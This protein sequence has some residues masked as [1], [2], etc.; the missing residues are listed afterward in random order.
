[1]KFLS[2][3]VLSLPCASAFAGFLPKSI[4]GFTAPAYYDVLNNADL[5][6]LAAPGDIVYDTLNQQYYGKGSTA[7]AT[8]SPPAGSNVVFSTGSNER[9]ERT[10]VPAT[11]TVN[12]VCTP[13]T[14][15]PGISV[16]RTSLGHYD[17]NF[18]PAFA[19]EPSCAIT[20]GGG[21]TFNVSWNS[22]ST[23]TFAFGSYD[24]VG[25]SYVDVSFSI[26]CQGAN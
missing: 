2:A 21:G 17:I 26:L 7:W 6:T 22:I 12:G 19:Q 14:S 16:S 5:T 18:S 24:V 15:T 25:L 20:L 9:V 3:L 4:I 23:S 10:S 8:L 13:S 1:M 11:C